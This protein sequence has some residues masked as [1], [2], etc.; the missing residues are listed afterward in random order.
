MRAN[1]TKP[2]AGVVRIRLLAVY[3]SVPVSAVRRMNG[4]G[5]LMRLLATR[6]VEI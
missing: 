3:D 5:D 4:L 2:I 6:E 1:L